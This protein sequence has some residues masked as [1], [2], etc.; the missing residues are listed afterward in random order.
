MQLFTFDTG[1]DSARAD[2]RHTIAAARASGE[3]DEVRGPLVHLLVRWTSIEGHRVAANDAVT[4]ANAAVAWVSGQLERAV[5]R[6]A[7]QLLAACDNDREGLTFKSYFAE[8]PSEVQ[9]LALEA[10]VER[11]EKWRDVREKV[12]VSGAAGAALAEVDALLPRG[13]AALDERKRATAAR[14]AVSIDMKAWR[15]EANLARRA[16]EVALDQH[17]AA[18]KLDRA[19]SADFFPRPKRRAKPK[20]DAKAPGAT[21]GAA[22]PATDVLA[23]PADAA[24]PRCA[25]ER[26][27]LRCAARAAPLV[28]ARPLTSPVPHGASPY[29]MIHTSVIARPA[30]LRVREIRS[31]LRR[32]A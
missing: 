29:V 18:K 27:A 2:V 31:V 20:T 22:K 8:R 10:K 14:H 30:R 21:K 19:Y 16:A 28:R 13:A 12:P 32:R 6:F 7:V 17:A 5:G 15:E 26:S 23:K 3:H 1:W 25:H 24:P 9:S 4:D 11:L